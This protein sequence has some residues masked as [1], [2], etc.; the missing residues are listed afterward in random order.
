V[1]FVDSERALQSRPWR[2]RRRRRRRRP[3]MQ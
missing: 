3:T 2:R 1:I